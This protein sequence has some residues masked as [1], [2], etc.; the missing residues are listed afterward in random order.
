[1]ARLRAAQDHAARDAPREAPGHRPSRSCTRWST[2]SSREFGDAYPELRS[3]RDAIV[4][5]VRS[6][7]E[8]FDAVLTG[9]LPR[10][11]E[12]LDRAAAGD[13][14]VAGDDAFRLYDTYGLPRDFI[15]DMIEDRKLTLDREGFERA[16]EG[17]REKARA[18]SA[19]KGGAAGRRAWNVAGRRG[20]R[21]AARSGT[22][23]RGY[24]ATEA[25]HAGR[26]A[27]P[28]AGRQHEFARAHAGRGRVRRSCRRRP[29]ISRRAARCRTSAGSSD[30]G[31]EAQVTDRLA[32]SP[33]RP[34]AARASTVTDGVAAQCATSSRPRSPAPCATRRGATTPRL[35]CCTRRCGRCSA[36]T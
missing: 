15:E 28:D 8:R 6:E 27:V 35:T 12:V 17:Q 4:Q 14:V 7:E 19:F 20:R 31:G 1:M 18:K 16:M 30:R 25:Q 2:P 23:F 33:V 10:L 13:R 36:P 22:S 9:G 29:S 11:E 5:V 3:G 24:D 26:R 32:P 34:R 21:A